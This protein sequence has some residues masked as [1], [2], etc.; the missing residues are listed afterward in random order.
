MGL[1]AP[2]AT[3]GVQMLQHCLQ[4]KGWQF[5]H[6]IEDFDTISIQVLKIEVGRV[7]VELSSKDLLLCDIGTEHRQRQS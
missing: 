7:A 6:M 1:L 5:V 4:L 2:N 3:T